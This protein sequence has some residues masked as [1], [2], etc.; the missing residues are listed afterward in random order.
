MR[1]IILLLGIAVSL[2]GGLILFRDAVV[3]RVSEN[4]FYTTGNTVQKDA[5]GEAS[6]SVP[7][8]RSFVRILFAGDLMLDRGVKHYIEKI[9]AGDYTFP[10][11]KIKTYL[12][13]F[14]AVIPN[15]EGPVSD[16]GL[17]QGNLYSFRM[18]P[19]IFDI[20]SYANIQAVNVA[21]NHAWDYGHDAFLD[22]ITRL[23][24]KNIGF[25]GGG[26]N[27][28][29]AYA[30]YV[31]EKNG[32]RIG[33]LGFTEFL[34]YAKAGE[35]SGGIAF[36]AEEK[37]KSSIQNA[38]KKNLDALI[39]IYHF[40]E[41]YRREPVNRQKNLARLAIDEGAD[42]VVGHHPHIIESQEVYKKKHI[43]YSLGNFVFDQG[44]SKET[45]I[46]GFLEIVVSKK[47]IESAILKKGSMTDYFEVI[48]PEK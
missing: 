1:K 22:T 16:K 41:E 35:A 19:K 7:A 13:S 36:A 42:L 33:I 46:P 47:G 4:T 27:E 9:G 43:F 39:V 31:L 11:V 26:E 8:R 28:A 5:S 45:M 12:D 3:R 38:K 10:F 2:L 15:L 32:I 44:F 18:D 37:I 34:E 20:F 17:N 40:G 14:D 6:A 24:E 23:K 30:P 48:P 29:E 21:N 25:F